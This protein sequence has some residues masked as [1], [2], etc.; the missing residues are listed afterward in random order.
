MARLV[1]GQCE[2][3]ALHLKNYLK[4]LFSQLY[5]TKGNTSWVMVGDGSGSPAHTH[6]LAL[7]NAKQGFRSHLGQCASPDGAPSLL[8]VRKTLFI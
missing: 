6:L 2:S 4:K 5:I 8:P 3:R 1:S 7:A